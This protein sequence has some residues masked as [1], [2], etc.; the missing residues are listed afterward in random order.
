MRAARSRFG[1]LTQNTHTV[2]VLIPDGLQGKLPIW[3]NPGNA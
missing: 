1:R 3:L 2:V